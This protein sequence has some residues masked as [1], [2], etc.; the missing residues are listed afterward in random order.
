M[1][2]FRD[3]GASNKIL[4]AVFVYLLNAINIHIV[5]V[6]MTSQSMAA[7][8]VISYQSNQCIPY[9]TQQITSR[10]V[11]DYRALLAGLFVLFSMLYFFFVLC[12]C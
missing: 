10:E 8:I 5:V 4:L 6:Q 11:V 9:V 1:G 7:I 2:M 12:F 3:V